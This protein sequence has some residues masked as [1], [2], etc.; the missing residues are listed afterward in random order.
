MFGTLQK[1]LPQEMRLHNITDMAQAN[2]FLRDVFLPAHN[3][4]FAKKAELEGSAFTPLYDFPLDDLLCIQEE[5]V[6]GNDNTVRYKGHVLQ[7]LPDGSCLHYAKSK[8]RVHEYPEGTLGVF[9]GPRKLAAVLLGRE[10]AI[11]RKSFQ[12]H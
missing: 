12:M 5:R 10:K 11:R 3:T 6:V 4:F 9:H 7:L 8:V 2:R 1:R